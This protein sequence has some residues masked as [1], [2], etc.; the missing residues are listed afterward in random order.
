MPA[1]LELPQPSYSCFGALMVLISQF[2]PVKCRSLNGDSRWHSLNPHSTSSRTVGLDA[3]EEVEEGGEE[4]PKARLG[5]SC[6]AD[7]WV[8]F[9]TVPLTGSIASCSKQ[10]FALCVVCLCALAARRGAL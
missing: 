2:A 6:P 10:P 1:L 3:S 9:G 8:C 4:P 5:L 7:S